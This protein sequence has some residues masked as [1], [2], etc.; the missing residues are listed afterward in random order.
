MKPPPVWYL[1]D[2][3][4]YAGKA[5]AGLASGPGRDQD[6]YLLTA[7]GLDPLKDVD[8]VLMSGSVASARAR[9]AS[10]RWSSSADR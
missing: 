4:R 9:C 7:A 2:A 8:K 6:A 1:H 5:I 3:S 10:R